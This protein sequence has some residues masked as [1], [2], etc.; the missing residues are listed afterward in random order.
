MLLREADRPHKF[1][2]YTAGMTTPVPNTLTDPNTP[3]QLG[4]SEGAA[5][6]AHTWLFKS[7]TLGANSTV[8][9]TWKHNQGRTWVFLK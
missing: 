8:G 5:Q 2:I 9:Q 4:Q 1:S 7:S 3:R 6:E